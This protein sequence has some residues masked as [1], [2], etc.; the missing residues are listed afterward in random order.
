MCPLKYVYSGPHTYWGVNSSA[1]RRLR[2][3]K[4]AAGAEAAA[5]EEGCCK[6]GRSLRAG[7]RPPHEGRL[8]RGRKV[9]AG[10]VHSTEACVPP[11]RL[12]ILYTQNI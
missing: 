3:R 12:S 7:R 9:I 1:L 6:D 2:G 4:V 8:L 11:G 5:G 10:R